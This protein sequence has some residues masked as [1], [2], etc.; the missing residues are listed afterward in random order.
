VEETDLFPHMSREPVLIESFELA[1]DKLAD[2][3]G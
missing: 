1:V 3:D 2:K